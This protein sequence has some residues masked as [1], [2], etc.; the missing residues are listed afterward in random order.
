MR[1]VSDALRW[2]RVNL[3]VNHL[4]A[5]NMSDAMDLLEVLCQTGRAV[6]PTDWSEENPTRDELE[7]QLRTLG[8][9]ER[10]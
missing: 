9:Y 3:E 1:P 7:A 4:Q 8:A 5:D 2:A 6:P 10:E